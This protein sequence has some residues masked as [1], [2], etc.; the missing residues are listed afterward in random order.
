MKRQ[1]KMSLTDGMYGN[2]IESA[3]LTVE[4][5]MSDQ[6]LDTE[7]LNERLHSQIGLWNLEVGNHIKI[8]LLN[9]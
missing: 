6:V 8:E 5:D 3:V 2:D 1:V 9:G 7:A 4:C